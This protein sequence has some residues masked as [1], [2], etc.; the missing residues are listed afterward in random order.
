MYGDYYMDG[1]MYNR[2]GLNVPSLPANC[3]HGLYD[4]VPDIIPCYVHSRMYSYNSYGPKN[5]RGPESYLNVQA[6]IFVD[7]FRQI[8]AIVGGPQ[9]Q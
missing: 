3:G 9:D 5:D 8:T 7:H 2:N 4:F 6:H 1:S